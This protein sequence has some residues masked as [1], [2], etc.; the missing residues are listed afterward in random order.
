ML[1]LASQGSKHHV[2]VMSLCP[3]TQENMDVRSVQVL[4]AAGRPRPIENHLRF[5]ILKEHCADGSLYFDGP[6]TPGLRLVIG[7]K[8]FDESKPGDVLEVPISL[9]QK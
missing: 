9:A 6:L 2:L 7:M 1:Q 8:P 4:D 5:F 3:S